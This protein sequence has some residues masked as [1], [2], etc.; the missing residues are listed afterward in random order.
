MTL[1][2]KLADKYDGKLVS[3]KPSSFSPNTGSFV[4]RKG[5]G[6][7]HSLTVGELLGRRAHCNADHG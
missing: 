1:I 3:Q 2:R 4:Q 5:R 6:D 7:G